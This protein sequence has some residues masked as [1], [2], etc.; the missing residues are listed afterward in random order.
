MYEYKL[1][2]EFFYDIYT[3]LS[4]LLTIVSLQGSSTYHNQ[5]MVHETLGN[6]PEKQNNEIVP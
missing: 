6:N 5:H 4:K 3:Y 2:V 1:L